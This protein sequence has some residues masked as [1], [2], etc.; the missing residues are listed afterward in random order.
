MYLGIKPGNILI[1]EVSP[2]EIELS[3]EKSQ[4]SGFAMPARKMPTY[5]VGPV[6]ARVIKAIDVETVLGKLLPRALAV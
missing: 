4:L 1:D 2:L 6:R 5:A 3:Y